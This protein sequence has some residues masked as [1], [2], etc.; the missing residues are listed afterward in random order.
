M[1]PAKWAEEDTKWAEEEDWDKESNA[2]AG[3]MQPQM[4][5][6]LQGLMHPQSDATGVALLPGLIQPF[7]AIGLQPI[8]TMRRI[9]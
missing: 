1:L 4:P 2:S 7:A 5:V 8:Q 9:E 6:G 3:L